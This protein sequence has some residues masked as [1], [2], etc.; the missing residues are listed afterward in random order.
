M[1]AHGG[2]SRRHAAIV[3]HDNGAAYAIDLGSSHG[4]FLGGSRLQPNK[5]ALL[6]NG[7][8]LT[9]GTGGPTYVLRRQPGGAVEEEAAARAAARA[10]AAAPPGGS[11]GKAAPPAPA[12]LVRASHLL[13]KHRGSRRPASFREPGGATRTQEEALA[14]LAGLREQLAA[15]ADLPAEFARLAAQHSMCSSHDRVRRSSC[16]ARGCFHG[17]LRREPSD[18]VFF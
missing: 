5:P 10:A 7:S 17:Q 4:T 16:F 12:S 2:A 14:I 8:Q 13:I 18:E 6:K 11:S 1:L 9:F 15:A 3:H